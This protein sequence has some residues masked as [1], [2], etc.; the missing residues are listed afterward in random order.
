MV[1]NRTAQVPVRRA[2]ADF[3]A[4][5]RLLILAGMAVLIG[6]GGAFAAWVLIKLIALV[7]NLKRSPAAGSTSHGNTGSIHMSSPGSPK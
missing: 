2:L 6:I 4:D 7:T 5:R 1:E 3:R